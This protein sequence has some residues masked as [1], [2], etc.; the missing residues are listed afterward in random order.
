M[1]A[2]LYVRVKMPDG[3][4][5]TT[6]PAYT[7]N[8]RIRPQVAMISGVA[9]RHDSATYVLRYVRHGRA[10]WETVGKDCN[11]ALA[12][13][14]RRNHAL[15]GEKLGL[16]PT[17]L[18][19]AGAEADAPILQTAKPVS[20]ARRLLSTAKK[21]Y[22]TEIELTKKPKTHAAYTTA[23]TYFEES[24]K[25]AKK[26][27][28]EDIDR[29]HMLNFHAYLRD[30]KKQ[31]PR[32]CWNKFS[33][34]MTFLKAH[35]IRRIVKPGDWPT[36]VEEEPEVYEQEELDAFFGVCTAEERIWFQFFLQTGMRE[37]EVMHCAWKN[38]NAKQSTVS[39]SWKPEFNWT[40][41]AYIRP[42]PSSDPDEGSFSP[43]PASAQR[44][45][46]SRSLQSRSACTM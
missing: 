16:V 14:E 32:S 29:R 31:S 38:L 1:K 13:L 40:P 28:L 17:A 5:L 34:V 44:T 19:V 9:E 7:A 23:L 33:N 3:R 41:K 22:L 43:M 21:E 39:V 42:E 8:G 35:E 20:D 6:R 46:E 24:C 37:Q 26:A 18:P 25:K 15:H 45:R 11:L 30:T 27:Y 4:Y 36:Y 12:A 2:S 10:T